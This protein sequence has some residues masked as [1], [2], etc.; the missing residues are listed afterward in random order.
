MDDKI[1]V[2]ICLT[3]IA[4]V[5]MWLLKDAAIASNVVSALAGVAVGKI[6]K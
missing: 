3:I 5:S 6:L 4:L 1:A 2:I